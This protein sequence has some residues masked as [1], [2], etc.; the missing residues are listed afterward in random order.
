MKNGK[1]DTQQDLFSSTNSCTTK[2]NWH[3]FGRTQAIND[4]AKE[5]IA[6]NS[7]IKDKN[8]IKLSFVPQGAGV[9]GGV[10]I[11]S[12]VSFDSIEKIVKSDDYTNYIATLKNYKSGG[13]YTCSSKDIE[14]Y[15]NYKL[16]NNEQ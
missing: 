11:L 12:S 14:L 4:V 1:K 5:K 7:V 9:Y 10:Y 15:I 3:L 6:I 2:S 16:D 8:S 13:Y